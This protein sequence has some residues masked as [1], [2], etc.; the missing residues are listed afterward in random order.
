MSAIDRITMGK[1]ARDVCS[2]A[3][4][5]KADFASYEKKLQQQGPQAS[6]L[7]NRPRHMSPPDLAANATQFPGT[8][9]RSVSY[10]GHESCNTPVA[11]A[12]QHAAPC[13]WSHAPKYG[14]KRTFSWY[15]SV[16]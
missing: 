8:P 12:S 2:Q 4:A 1:I 16:A 11:T 15:Q 13:T 7:V 10:Q 6:G 14:W 5:V 3:A 9:A